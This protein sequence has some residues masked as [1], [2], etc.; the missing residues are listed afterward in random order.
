MDK[1]GRLDV[2]AFMTPAMLDDVR[3]GTLSV[4]CAPAFQRAIDA[5]SARDRSTL[6]AGQRLYVPGGDILLGAP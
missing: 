1:D 6:M 4:D 5:A 2:T 3:A